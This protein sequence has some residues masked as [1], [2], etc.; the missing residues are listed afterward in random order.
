MRIKTDRR[1][2]FSLKYFSNVYLNCSLVN[3]SW[4]T[5]CTLV[6]T[7]VMVTSKS[8]ERH[9]EIDVTLNIDVR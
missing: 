1:L 7:C 2:S 3:S 9:R 4:D 5:D 6:L 8:V